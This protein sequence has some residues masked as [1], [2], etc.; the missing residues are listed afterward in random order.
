M[1]I[2]RFQKGANTECI[3]PFKQSHLHGL[4]K[5]R[6]VNPM[7]A[8]A[9][10]TKIPEDFDTSIHAQEILE[11]RNKVVRGETPMD[12]LKKYYPF[13]GEMPETMPD[14]LKAKGLCF[15]DPAKLANV[16]HMDRPTDMPFA[17]LDWLTNP[18]HP[19]HQG[20]NC[21]DWNPNFINFLET[22]PYLE[23][24]ITDGVKR[25]LK[26]IFEVKYFY[27]VARPEEVL[28]LNMTAYPEGCP[29]H[30]SMGQGHMAAAAGGTAIILREFSKNLSQAQIKEILDITY[31]WGQF[32]CLAGVH[33]GQDGLMSLAISPLKKYMRKEVRKKYL[34]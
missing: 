7:I 22:V 28:G 30:P 19:N 6:L 17:V 33:Y 23:E 5:S 32:R 8:K 16:V 20:V 13:K 21:N 1:R 2:Q 10:G 25:G 34:A 18:I 24:N 14:A 27:G 12:F 3:Y 26:R 29:N 31:L 15:S 11:V 9:H 4:N